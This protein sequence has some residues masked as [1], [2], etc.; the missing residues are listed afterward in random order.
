MCHVSLSDKNS[1]C[2]RGKWVS[3]E[4]NIERNTIIAKREYAGNN[5]KISYVVNDDTIA[6]IIIKIRNDKNE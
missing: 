1:E 5:G 4:F 2:E 3:K 6:S